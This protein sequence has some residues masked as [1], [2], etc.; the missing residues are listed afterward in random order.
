[1][2]LGN[3]DSWEESGQ[4]FHTLIKFI[5]KDK[6]LQARMKAMM[7]RTQTHAELTGLLLGGKLTIWVEFDGTHD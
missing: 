6:L 1:M 3:F 4:F 2:V 7:E 5:G